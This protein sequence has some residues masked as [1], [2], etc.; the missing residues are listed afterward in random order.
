[1]LPS[2]KH[3]R[4]KRRCLC[5]NSII[6][7]MIFALPLWNKIGSGILA[8]RFVP[9]LCQAGVRLQ[10]TANSTIIPMI[11]F[12]SLS[13]QHYGYQNYC[14]WNLDL[15]Y[16]LIGTRSILTICTRSAKLQP[17]SAWETH[18]VLLFACNILCW[19]FVNG[20]SSLANVIITNNK[21]IVRISL[22]P[23]LTK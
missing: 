7:G 5:F 3:C 2:R 20:V 18:T 12:R 10:N 15:H 23:Q 9:Q 6:K 19:R 8:L 4:Q 22:W 1:M 16:K 21:F 13:H 17:P 14:Q 11:Y